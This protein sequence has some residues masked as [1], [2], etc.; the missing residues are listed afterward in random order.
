MTQI[1]G[2]P[3]LSVNILEFQIY[4]DYHLRT[5]ETKNDVKEHIFT[6]RCA[7]T[8]I[9]DIKNIAFTNYMR[10]FVIRYENF[11]ANLVWCR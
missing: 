8:F 11:A 6:T 1:H 4:A 7:A 3:A 5:V 9:C 10:F 2:S